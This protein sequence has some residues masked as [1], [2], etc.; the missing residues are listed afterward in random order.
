MFANGCKN[1]L[2]SDNI[3]DKTKQFANI[4]L[5]KRLFEN[6]NHLSSPPLSQVVEWAIQVGS[7]IG[8]TIFWSH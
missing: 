5:V 3:S 4:S 1:V 6:P 2:V 8:E 7:K